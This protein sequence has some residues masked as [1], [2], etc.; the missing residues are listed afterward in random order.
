MLTKLFLKRKCKPN[1]VLSFICLPN[2]GLDAAK[3]VY[4]PADDLIKH[5]SSAF[6]LRCRI[7]GNH[8]HEIRWIK[9][10]QFVEPASKHIELDAHRLTI[11]HP[12]RGDS[13]VYKCIAR[14]RIGS[15]QSK[16][17]KVEFLA[18]DGYHVNRHPLVCARFNRDSTDDSTAL[19]CGYKRNDYR[20]QAK[21]SAN[22]EPEALQKPA[23]KRFN[24]DEARG[25][26]LNCDMRHID[27]DAQLI[28]RWK[29]DGKLIR[30]ASLNG[31]ST[32]DSI[33][34]NP[35]ENPLLRDDGRLSVHTKNGSLIITSTI[36][37]DSGFYECSVSQNGNGISSVNTLELT[38]IEKLKFSPAPT[39]SKGLEM[40]SIGKIHCK[41]QGTPTPQ[42]QWI[43]V[44]HIYL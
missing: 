30:Q 35:L 5:A 24:V 17:L 20:S 33:N 1:L 32:G 12:I 19:L 37:S 4:H 22:D 31:M 14:N 36:P 41:V 7:N 3:V 10:N 29:K 13:G 25:A 18:A 42:I 27:R 21:R 6:T 39:S 2:T 16:P 9:D 38:I 23:R 15:I 43:K 34:I 11:R 8:L 26:I 40:G 28:V 44:R